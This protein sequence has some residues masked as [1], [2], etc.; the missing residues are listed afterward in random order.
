MD[1]NSMNQK[2]IAIITVLSILLLV[3]A[4]CASPSGSDDAISNDSDVSVE[5]DD[6]NTDDSN[7]DD[8]SSTTETIDNA[9][10]NVDNDSDA[11]GGEDE[12]DESGAEGDADESDAEGDT[13]RDDADEVNAAS[14]DSSLMY[15]GMQ[16]GY[17]EEGFVYRG[18]P[19]APITI[20][21][22]SDYQ[23]PFCQR[24]FYQT[25]PGLDEQ[26]VA[27]GTVRFV[28]VDF[29]LTQLHPNAPAAHTASLCVADQSPVTFWEMHNLIF[30]TQ[31]QWGDSADPQAELA[32]LVEQLDVDMELYNS[33]VDEGSKEPIITASVAQAQQLGFGGTPSF[34]FVMEETGESYSLVG[35]QPLDKFSDWIETMAE[36]E[37][38]QDAVADEGGQEG[39]GEIPYWATA[40]GLSPD[41]DKPG[42]T[43]AGDA[44]RGSEDAEVV[45]IEYS[46]FQCPFCG[47]HTSQTQPV[48]DETFVDTGDVRWV[49]KHFPLNI[50]PQAPAAGV[51]AECA[52]EQGEFWRMHEELFVGMSSWSIREPNPVFIDIADSMGLDMDAF[53][54]CLEEE[55]MMERV[56]T[57]FEAG[58]PFVQGTPTFIVMAGDAG[59][60]IPG[61]LPTDQFTAAL[62]Q[63]L[64]A[65][66]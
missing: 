46:D 35:A 64:D 48:L 42:F 51:A 65:A 28:F 5:V 39:G 11:S 21:E 9:P 56:T 54:A 44:Y 27:D 26:Y 10:G 58:R 61:A 55:E 45:V 19:D 22:Y 36:G 3:I 24:H 12:I 62:Q 47:R 6:S 57:D 7:T 43:K 29:P 17:T 16:V 37:V 41:P 60:I 66:E 33:C 1:M 49:F 15:N 50:H 13:D 14:D 23:C 34:L 4:S 63:V 30:E 53:A 38:P 31:N 25:E 20:Y 18:S 59:R 40:D 8:S 52:G 32:T 2:R